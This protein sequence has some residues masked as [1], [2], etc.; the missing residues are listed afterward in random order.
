MSSSELDASYYAR[1]RRSV[2]I[3]AIGGVLLPLMAVLFWGDNNWAFNAG[4]VLAGVDC[5]IASYCIHRSARRGRDLPETNQRL[6]LALSGVVVLLM[7][8]AIFV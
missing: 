5:L 2:P 1:L 8:A 3:F 7:I 6:I 4:L